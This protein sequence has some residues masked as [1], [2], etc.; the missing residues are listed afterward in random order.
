[1]TMISTIVGKNPLGKKEQPLQVN[2]SPEC[3]TWGQ[4]QKWQNDLGSF[5]RQTIQRH[6]NQSLHPNPD[7]LKNLFA[8]QEAP[9]QFLSQE[10]PLEKGYAT[11]SSILGL[12]WWLSWW[13]IC[14]QCRRPG[15]IG[16][17]P[18]EGNGFTPVFWPREFHGQKSME[19]YSP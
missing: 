17:S 18:G 15:F 3:S 2:K 4:S 9:V 11:H 5:A 12:P 13:R 7:N 1:M 6:S 10:D 14:P 16:W 19:G 8:M